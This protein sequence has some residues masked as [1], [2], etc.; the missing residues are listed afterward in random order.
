MIDFIAKVKNEQGY[1]AQTLNIGGGMGVRYVE[2]DPE[3]D[4]A[5]NIKSLSEIF[6]AECA[7][8]KVNMPQI[9]MEPGRS[10]VADAGMTLYTVGAKKKFRAL[11][12]MFRLTA[13]CRIIRDMRFISR[14]TLFVLQTE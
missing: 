9:L 5:A 14:N 11:R 8:K 6:K 2:S 4:Y 3:I 12:T 7:E 13:V 1:E 10:I